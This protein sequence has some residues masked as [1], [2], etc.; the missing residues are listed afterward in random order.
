MSDTNSTPAQAQGNIYAPPEAHVDD[1]VPEG[2]IALANRE[3]RLVSAIIDSILLGALNGLFGYLIGYNIFTPESPPSWQFTAVLTVS[4]CVIFLL[5]NGYLLAKNAQTIGKKLMKIKIVRTDG[6]KATFG[7]I[8]GLRL[9]PVWIVSAIPFVGP[10]ISI[11][12]VLFIFR[13][14]R[15]CLHDNIA[16]TIVIKA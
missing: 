15:K 10:A 11:V 7:R 4:G 2:E 3:T 14:N 1:V 6:K 16:D 9:L 5:I 13:E 8:V 12:D